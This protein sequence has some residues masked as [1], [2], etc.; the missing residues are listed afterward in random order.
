[1][2]IYEEENKGKNKKKRKE[3]MKLLWFDLKGLHS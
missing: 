3:R 1:M 2:R